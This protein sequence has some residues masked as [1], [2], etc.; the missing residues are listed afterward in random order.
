MNIDQRFMLAIKNGK[1]VKDPS[2]LGIWK[3]VREGINNFFRLKHKSN[4][5]EFVF[6]LKFWT[7]Q[8]DQTTHFDLDLLVESADPF[9]KFYFPYMEVKTPSNRLAQLAELIPLLRYCTKEILEKSTRWVGDGDERDY[10]VLLNNLKNAS[11]D[12]VDC[13]VYLGL[14][15]GRVNF[16]LRNSDKELVQK[17]ILKL[18]KDYRVKVI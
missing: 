3:N 4:G 8:H 12:T 14:D 9:D 13:F 17:K 10:G 16:K 5:L 1:S 2:G 18:I 15:R 11:M 6:L 7:S